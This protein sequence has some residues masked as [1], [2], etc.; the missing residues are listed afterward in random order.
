MD[1]SKP[2]SLVRSKS[3]TVRVLNMPAAKQRHQAQRS[4][5]HPGAG[6]K[7]VNLVYSVNYRVSIEPNPSICR[8]IA[9]NTSWFLATIFICE[10]F[11]KPIS[12]ICKGT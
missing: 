4:Q 5:Q 1:L 8:L 2:T 6:K 7:T 11:S 3:E 12:E 9:G 10:K